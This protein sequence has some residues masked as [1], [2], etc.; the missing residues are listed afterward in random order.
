ME[1]RED[2]KHLHKQFFDVV[3][4]YYQTSTLILKMICGREIYLSFSEAHEYFRTCKLHGFSDKC[5]SKL[6]D[7]RIESAIQNLQVRAMSCIYTAHA[8]EYMATDNIVLSDRYVEYIK[9]LQKITNQLYE[10]ADN[11]ISLADKWAEEHGLPLFKNGKFNI[12]MYKQNDIK[13]VLS[14]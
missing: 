9:E 14:K 2:I 6:Y 12:N 13:N 1:F 10:L 4:D 5:I 11:S 3:K 8:I 7:K